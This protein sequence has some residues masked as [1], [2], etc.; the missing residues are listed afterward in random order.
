MVDTKKIAVAG[1]AVVL[2]AIVTIFASSYMSDF[3]NTRSSTQDNS[4]TYELNMH[5][6]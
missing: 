1:A 4:E 3:E 2:V 6:Y 5:L